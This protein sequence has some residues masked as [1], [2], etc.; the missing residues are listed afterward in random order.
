MDTGTWANVPYDSHPNEERWILYAE[1]GIHDEKGRLVGGYATVVRAVRY[2]RDHCMP[3]KT[4]GWDVRIQS[5]RNGTAYGATAVRGAEY[6]TLNEAKAGAE[7]GL[8]AQ[9]KRYAKKYR[10]GA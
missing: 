2:T 4:G 5:T 9:G 7:R 10:K 3:Y 1:H 8:V 6:S